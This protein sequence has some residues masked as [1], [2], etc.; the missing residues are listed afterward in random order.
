MGVNRGRMDKNIETRGGAMKRVW[1]YSILYLYK[2]D[3]RIT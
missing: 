3:V 2:V 1:S